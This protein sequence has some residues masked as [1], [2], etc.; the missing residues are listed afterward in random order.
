MNLSS[1]EIAQ[2]VGKIHYENM[3]IQIYWKLFTKK[4]KI[5]R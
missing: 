4:M 1:D 3:H 5:F 2:N